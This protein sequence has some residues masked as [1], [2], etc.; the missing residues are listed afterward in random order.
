MGHD[1]GHRELDGLSNLFFME[2][3]LL[4]GQTLA[5]MYVGRTAD[6]LLTLHFSL[7]VWTEITLFLFTNSVFSYATN[8]CS[9]RCKAVLVPLIPAAF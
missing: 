3:L 2:T 7:H 1:L 6:F 9:I 4:L 5:V 8:P